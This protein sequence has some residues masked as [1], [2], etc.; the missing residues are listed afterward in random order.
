M[1]SFFQSLVC[2]CLLSLTTLSSLSAQI[3]TSFLFQLTDQLVVTPFVRFRSS[4]VS[5]QENG[6]PL[7]FHPTDVGGIGLRLT[8]RLFGVSGTIPV[9]DFNT[10]QAGKPQSFGLG[11]FLMIGGWNLFGSARY[12][13]GVSVTE[14]LSATFRDDIRWL[15]LEGGAVYA[16][17]YQ[18]YR[19]NGPI[20]FPQ[21]QRRSAGSLLIMPMV[22][23]V[24]FWSEQ[25]IQLNS[26][27]PEIAAFGTY[28]S[29]GAGLGLGYGYNWM[30]EQWY[31]GA[32]LIPAFKFY[33]S[34]FLQDT[35]TI[36]KMIPSFSP[37]GYIAIGR[38]W[39]R[40]FAGINAEY[41]GNLAQLGT[42]GTNNNHFTIYLWVGFIL[43]EPKFM[44]RIQ[45]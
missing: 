32:A 31:A 12:L 37:R 24:H 41:E 6:E 3:D 44:Q 10:R 15:G 19:F 39:D 28:R 22:H 4:D 40:G 2:Y 14:D 9:K 20:R 30:H 18:R 43:D 13:K 7:L 16:W 11:G 42:I 35:K 34:T 21:F 38:H 29:L 33:S 1:K 26:L 8:T 23:I 25:P 36:S 17:N 5:L 45:W 27:T